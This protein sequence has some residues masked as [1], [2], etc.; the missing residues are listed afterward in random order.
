MRSCRRRCRQEE[1]LAA[2]V[3]M[4]LAPLVVDQRESLERLSGWIDRW[5]EMVVAQPVSE[6]LGAF[7]LPVLEQFGAFDFV[8]LLGQIF[9]NIP[10]CPWG[11]PS[12]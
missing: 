6:L 11:A 5:F 12:S 2:N 7:L 3:A 4:V 10:L 9:F 8:D 1:V